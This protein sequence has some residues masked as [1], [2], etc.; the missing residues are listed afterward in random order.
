MEINNY[1]IDSYSKEYLDRCVDNFR[2]SL[3]NEAYLF[4]KKN[5][6]NQIDISSIDYALHKLL[7]NRDATAVSRLKRRRYTYLGMLIGLIYTLCGCIVFFIQNLDFQPDKD[8]GQMIIGVGLA[9]VVFFACW[10]TYSNRKHI[11]ENESVQPHRQFL[12][13]EKWSEIEMMV[14]SIYQMKV[15][16]IQSILPKLLELCKDEIS[17]DDISSVLYIRNKILHDNV[18][19]SNFEFYNSINIENKIIDLLKAK[20]NNI[21]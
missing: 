10:G 16:T 12:V 8:L 20:A 18:M 5:G 2:L 6:D 7:K 19:L 1:N 14:S 3:L 4:A 17:V 21:K 9:T 15:I 13:V 11:Y